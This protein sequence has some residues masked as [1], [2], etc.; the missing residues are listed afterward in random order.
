MI[1]EIVVIIII[2]HC[3]VRKKDS[4]YTDGPSSS[5]LNGKILK[6]YNHIVLGSAPLK[7]LHIHPNTIYYSHFLN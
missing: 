6:N 4:Q 2:W 5:M 1:T 7:L 3:S